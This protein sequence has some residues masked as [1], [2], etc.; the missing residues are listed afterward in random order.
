[1]L[2]RLKTLAQRRDLV[3]ALAGIVL[4]AF[5]VNVVEFLCSAG[6]PAVFAQVL[7]LSDLAPLEYFGYLVLYVA[8]FM[9]DDLVV[10][11][12]A[13]KTLEATGLTTRYARWSNAI[14]GV[15]LLVIGALLIFRPEWLAFA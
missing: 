13:L 1:V 5:V 14:G 2:E 3:P 15:V 8:V 4:L 12:A 9:L 7:A 11:V 10:L 6:I